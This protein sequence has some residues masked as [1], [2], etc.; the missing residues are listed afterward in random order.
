MEVKFGTGGFRGV[1]G[2]NFTKENVEKICQAMANI[3]NKKG[4]KKNICI[5]YDNRFMSENFAL[6]CAI[7]F[8]GNDFEVKL[9][10]NATSTPV[11]MYRTMIEKNDYG[12]MITASHNPYLYNGVKV[13]T[14]QGRDASAKETKE[15]EDEFAKV[16][17]IKFANDNQK[18]K[19]QLVDYVQDFVNYII[20]KQNIPNCENLKV[21]FDTKFGSTSEE[22]KHLCSQ[23]GLTNYSIINEKRDAFFNFVLPAPSLDNVGQLKE[24]VLLQK[25]DIGFALDADGDR[26]AVID[27][28][29]N[30][31]DNNIILGLVYYYL[32]KYENQKGDV[33]KNV[34]TSS[35]LDKLAKKFGYS[36]YEVPVGFKYISSKLIEKNAVVGGESSGGLALLNH[37]YGKDSLVSI[38]LIL[39]IIS[40]L[41]KPFD[42]IVKEM[43]CFADGFSKIMRDRQYSYTKVFSTN[44]FTAQITNVNWTL[45]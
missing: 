14:R 26:L 27:R 15:I 19:I 8:A 5:G 33:V 12:V 34:A 25:A 9:F 11:V 36:C 21:V 2:D 28:Y 10:N 13:F 35:L 4:F 38:A 17:E 6:W 3:A 1:I 22:I 18:G 7:V 31:L 16:D 44:D 24:N 20:Q 30:F 32:V 23:I 41:N 39:K 29:G 45:S 42:E 40:K 43:L 37:I